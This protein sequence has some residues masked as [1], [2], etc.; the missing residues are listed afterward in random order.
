LA[1]DAAH[2]HPKVLIVESSGT[3]PDFAIV[4][5]G[6]LSL[7]GLHNN[8]ECCVYV[9]DAQAIGDISAWFECQF[10]SALKLTPGLIWKYSLSYKKN[11]SRIKA[12]EK[13]ERRVAKELASMGKATI[14]EWNDLVKRAEEYFRSGRY[15]GDYDSRSAGAHRILS[16]L[17]YRDNFEFDRDGWNAFYAIRELGRLRGHR[18][19]VFRK[20]NRVKEA[21]RK[22]DSGG[23]DALQSVL[24]RGGKF[25]VPGFGV[26][27]VSKILASHDPKTWPVYNDR[28]AAVLDDFGYKAERGAGVARRYLAYKKAMTDFMAACKAKD[29]LALDAFFLHL[30]KGTKKYKKAA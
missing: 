21:L 12:V 6:N 16:A 13:D 22:L 7:G 10:A 15:D 14:A 29:A 25:Y 18:D 11:E 3:Q 28:V 9:E 8:T 4:G 23:E 26:A 17:K 19:Q 30:S 5:S 20:H 24:D 1:T 2:F 27:T